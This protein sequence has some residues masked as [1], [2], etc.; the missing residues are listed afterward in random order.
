MTRA[1]SCDMIMSETPRSRPNCGP[2]WQRSFWAADLYDGSRWLGDGGK[3]GARVVCDADGSIVQVEASE[4]RTGD[5]CV[6]LLIPGLVNAHV[7]LELDLLER[8]EGSFVDWLGA[9]MQSRSMLT[10]EEHAALAR[11]NLQQALATG[12]CSFAEMDTMGFGTAAMKELGVSGRSYREVVGFDVPA[13]EAEKVLAKRLDGADENMGL[14]PHA[15]YSVSGPLFEASARSG[16]MLSVHVSESSEEHEFFESGTGPFHELLRSLGKL[17]H[18]FEAPRERPVAFLDRLGVLTSRTLLVHM[19]E[20]PPEDFHVVKER[21]AAIVICP[22]TIEYF[23][24]S[25]PDLPGILAQGIDVGVG[26]DSLASNDRLDLFEELRRLRR[27]FPQLAASSL[28]R[29]G[30]SGSARALR[31]AAG[32]IEAGSRFD[33]VFSEQSAEDLGLSRPQHS[34]QR[35]DE[36]LAELVLHTG[37]GVLRVLLRGKEYRFCG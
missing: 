8:P 2:D 23:D 37:L 21:G 15:P 11:R 24:R 16:R 33:A 19:T 22:G 31:I 28:L 27:R 18:T 20:A 25:Y 1:S 6:G 7:H 10:G 36:E 26:T 29:L 30:T 9:V 14:A 13:E 4:A 17:P 34:K 3:P 35:R 32:R 5:H 12:T